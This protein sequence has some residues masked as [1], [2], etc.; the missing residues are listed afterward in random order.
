MTEDKFKY[1][2]DVLD[3]DDVDIKPPGRYNVIMYNDNYTTME[4]VV[5]VLI[6]V[7]NHSRHNAEKLMQDIHNR[8]K[9]VAGTY[10]YEI[11]ETKVARIDALAMKEG[12]PL[13]C[14]IEEA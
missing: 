7:F 11:A 13:K 1:D 9:A 6:N 14:K 12:Y 2:S 5:F 10:S 8:G 3:A 4:F